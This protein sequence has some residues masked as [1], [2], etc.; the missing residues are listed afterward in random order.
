VVCLGGG[1][2][3]DLGG[4]LAAV[5]ARGVSFVNVPTTLLAAVDASIGGK[6][7]VNLPEGKN[8]AGAFHQPRAVLVDLDLLATLPAAEWRNGWAEVIKIAITSDPGLVEL[9]ESGAPQEDAA[10][11]ERAVELACRAKAAIVSADERST[12]ATRWGTRSRPREAMGAGAMANR[13]RSGSP[14]SSSWACAW[15]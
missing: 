12:S 8:L 1:S 7:G 4:F 9:L 6:T 2:V 5:Y 3:G 15:A 14:A 10:A 11:L 13:S